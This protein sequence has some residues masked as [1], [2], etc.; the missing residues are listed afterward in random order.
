MSHDYGKCHACG[1]PMEERL[2]D[3]SLRER[4]EWVVVRSVPTGVCTRCGEQVFSARV[5]KRL[6][7]IL[8]DRKSRVPE[9]CIEVPVFAY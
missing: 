4:G 3:H 9:V 8:E 1:A 6:E 7:Q 5:L 2:T